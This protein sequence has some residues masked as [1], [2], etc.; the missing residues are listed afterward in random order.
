MV[1]IG[2]MLAEDGMQQTLATLNVVSRVTHEGTLPSLYRKLE[3][4]ER[5]DFAYI[6]GYD[7]PTGWKRTRYVVESVDSYAVV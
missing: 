5:N 3:L 7:V 6:T 2:E 4:K 1:L